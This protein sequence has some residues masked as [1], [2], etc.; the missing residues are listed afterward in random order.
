MGELNQFTACELNQFTACGNYPL[1]G[2]KFCQLH[3]N[4]K[5]M[6]LDEINDFGIL[7]RAKRREY[8]LDVDCLTTLE[9]CRK[10]DNINVRTER[11][12]TAG[13]NFYQ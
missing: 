1:R 3:L 10:K 13:M 4:D 9:G 5:K 12:R 2:E 8:G 11:S 7:T 6:E